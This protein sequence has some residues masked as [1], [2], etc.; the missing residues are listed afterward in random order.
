MKSYIGQP[1]ESV[2]IDYGT[3][4]AVIELG[5]GQ[6]A[7]QWSKISTNAVASSTSGE[8]RD[9]R[10]GTRYEETTKPGYVEEQECVYTF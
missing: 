5:S 8:Y 9:I 7:Y 10:R 6:R 3:L 4:T 1:L 2:I